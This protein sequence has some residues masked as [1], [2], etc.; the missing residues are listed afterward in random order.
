MAGRGACK[1]FIVFFIA[2]CFLIK[3]ALLIAQ[4]GDEFNEMISEYEQKFAH[5][6]Y[7]ENIKKRLSV[8]YHNYARLLADDG[9]WQEAITEEKRAYDLYPKEEA[10]LKTLAYF[11]N[12]Y[13]LELKS[14]GKFNSA[15][16]NLSSAI[17]YNPDEPQLKKNTAMLYLT[18]ANEMFA[19]A[20]YSNAERM[21]QNSKQFDENNPY[22]Y[23]LLG[24]IAYLR[25]N[26]FK[27]HEYWSKALELN[28]S[29]YEIR[30]KLEK[31]E[32]EKEL[33]GNFNIREV[34]NFKL[35]FEGIEKEELAANAAEILRNAYRDVGQDFNV[36]PR[37]I[38][39]V[40]IYPETKLSELDYFPDW[41]AGSYDGKIRFGEHLGKNELNMKAVLYHEYTHVIVRILAQD[42][43]PLWL[44][45]GLAEHEAE[46]FKRV[47][48]K[49]IRKQKL[50]KAVEK[51][52]IFDI[53]HLSKMDLTKLTYL[54]PARIELVYAQSESFVNYLIN[55]SSIFDMKNI[56]VRLGKGESVYKAVKEVLFV[57]LD[58]LERDWI[59]ELKGQ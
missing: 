52:V 51:N 24:E 31:L 32:K 47:E 2:A 59:V 57:D 58:K 30:Y 26:Y 17:R 15:L 44:N 23:V 13:S 33:E 1:I 43:V 7:D 38:V 45:E 20:E 41:A 12:E 36:Y 34:D 11:H 54:S 35:K 14:E 16:E 48:D 9:L 49:K 10:I 56:L 46:E 53:D 28:S 6:P 29:L 42:N 5:N 18:L 25:D 21:L 8:L 40:I 37:Q 22:L 4:T 19:K 27:T 39:P 50:L 3:P 55:R